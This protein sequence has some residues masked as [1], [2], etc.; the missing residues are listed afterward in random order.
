MDWIKETIT[1]HALCFHKHILAIMKLLC[2]FFRIRP[3]VRSFKSN[4]ERNTNKTNSK[5]GMF[6]LHYKENKLKKMER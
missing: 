1:V 6:S 4:Q 5:S 3:L 2:A